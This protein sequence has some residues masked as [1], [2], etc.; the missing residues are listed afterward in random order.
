MKKT[1]IAIYAFTILFSAQAQW[2]P[3]GNRIKTPWADKMDV[4]QV[5][6]EYPRPLLERNDW[7][8]LN[9]LWSYAIRPV[10]ETC[11][12]KFDGDILVPFAVESSLSG[13]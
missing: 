4:N 6:P 9:G 7:S 10:G 2:K 1:V 11:P 8:N 5:L 3:T 13:V 12:T